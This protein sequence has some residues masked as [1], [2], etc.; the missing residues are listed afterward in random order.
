MGENEGHIWNLLL[1]LINNSFWE[2]KGNYNRERDLDMWSYYHKIWWNFAF[3]KLY[4]TFERVFHPISKHL[5]IKKRIKF[6]PPTP[7]GPY[8]IMHSVL[9]KRKQWQKQYIAI[10]KTDLFYSSMGLCGN[11]TSFGKIFAQ[12]K[13]YLFLVKFPHS[14]KQHYAFSSWVEKT[15]TKTIHR[16]WENRFVLQ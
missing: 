15:M 2:S 11:F 9:G 10:E 7:P 5:E 13:F 16:H 8:Y 3:E 6:P 14:P 1:K 12:N 4:R